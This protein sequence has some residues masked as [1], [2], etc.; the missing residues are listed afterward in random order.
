MSLILPGVIASGRQASGGGVPPAAFTPVDLFGASETGVWYDFSDMG[1]LYQDSTGTIPV[2][3][4]GQRV[5]KVL[6]K[7]GNGLHATQGTST[8]RPIWISDGGAGFIYCPGGCALVVPWLAAA[9]AYSMRAAMAALGSADFG[10]SSIWRFGDEER[11]YYYHDS[12]GIYENWQTTARR[13]GILGATNQLTVAQSRYFHTYGIES[14]ATYKLWHNGTMFYE[15]TGANT[16][17]NWTSV[18]DN[19]LGLGGSGYDSHAVFA[20][21]VILGRALTAAEHAD[22]EAYQ[23]T[24]L[25]ALWPD[26][27][28]EL[29]VVNGGA[30]TGDMTGWTVSAG[31]VAANTNEK[32]WDGLY[33]FSAGADGSAAY[34]DLIIPPSEESAV[35]AGSRQARVLWRGGT[36]GPGSG[37][38]AWT[39]MTFGFLDSGGSE[40]SSASSPD[41]EASY[42]PEFGFS[43]P[44]PANTRTIRLTFTMADPCGI[45]DI[46][47]GLDA[48]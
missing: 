37:S 6:D 25:A 32:W 5:G 7:S 34:Q 28:T 26:F 31:S 15:D 40:I 13:G 22:L 14:G 12:G 36:G 42:M 24:V 45:D 21:L 19:W 48:I 1:T 41:Y 35:D 11:T 43:A 9:S 30:E 23:Q 17:S 44:V 16:V 8:A 4:S 20:D 46:K 2:T 33:S 39:R 18:S 47:C 27:G 3:A 10:D 29:G 38:G